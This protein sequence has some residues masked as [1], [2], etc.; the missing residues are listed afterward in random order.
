M[1]SQMLPSKIDNLLFLN[2][3]HLNINITKPTYQ[4]DNYVA[5]QIIKYA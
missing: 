1:L 3:I 2:I 5:K 4:T